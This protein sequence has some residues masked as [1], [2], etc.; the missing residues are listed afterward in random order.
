[1]ADKLIDGELA[2]LMPFSQAVVRLIRAIPAGSVATY[3]D[4]AAAAGS[5]RGARQVARLL[6]SASDKYQLPWHRVLNQT[7]QIALTDTQAFARQQQLLRD[8]GVEMTDAGRVDL[9][10]Y[11]WLPWSTGD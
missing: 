10:R 9:P 5:P 1:V 6:H 11:R 4:I 7:G 8:E 2:T 3:G